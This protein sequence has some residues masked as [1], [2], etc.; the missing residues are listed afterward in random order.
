MEDAGP[1][2]LG[3]MMKLITDG[4]FHA[5]QELLAD[6]PKA[7]REGALCSGTTKGR[8]C[9]AGRGQ[10]LWGE[11][12][13]DEIGSIESTE[14]AVNYFR[15]VCAF[16]NVNVTISFGHAAAGQQSLKCRLLQKC[17]DGVADRGSRSGGILV[18]AH[19]SKNQN[20]EAAVA[21]PSLAGSGC[22][23]NLVCFERVGEVA[24]PY[25]A[26]MLTS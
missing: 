3:I 24:G 10:F 8:W 13:E 15:F 21:I 5:I 18:I 26:A 7:L 6:L 14:N 22:G 1:H 12:K 19:W 25:G 9:A 2:V 20:V 17:L 11:V 16:W 4:G 23:H